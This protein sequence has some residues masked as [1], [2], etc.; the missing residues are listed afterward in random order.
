M[1]AAR[2]QRAAAFEHEPAPHQE[3]DRDA[4]ISPPSSSNVEGDVSRT[5]R[6]ISLGAVAAVGLLPGVAPGLRAGLDLHPRRGPTFKVEVDYFWDQDA[7]YDAAAG[8]RFS[9]AWAGLSVC[10]LHATIVKTR[11]V[12]CIA[13]EAGALR[14]RSYETSSSAP[15][16][17]WLAL[18]SV[19]LS[20]SHPIGGRWALMASGSVFVPWVRDTFEIHDGGRTTE[21]F[22]MAGLGAGLDL[23][24]GWRF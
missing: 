21:L 20:A 15:E 6:E 5:E 16:L 22:R 23:S 12:A 1:L 13:A 4:D 10:P 7:S 17:R 14:F 18:S 11:L 2:E 8:T 3:F 9:M 24:M 19:G